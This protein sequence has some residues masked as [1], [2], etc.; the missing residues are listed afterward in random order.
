MK[1]IIILTIIATL[2]G[3][4]FDHVQAQNVSSPMDIRFTRQA[5]HRLVFDEKNSIPLSMMKPGKIVN[6]SVEYPLIKVSGGKTSYRVDKGLL[7]ASA[8]KPSESA[9][10][11]G[12]FNPFATYDIS[13]AD[14]EENS[15]EAGVEF[16]TP[17]N[18]N[19][20]M[21]LAGFKGDKCKTIRWQ[22]IVKGR[23]KEE[24]IVNLKKP[25]RGA[26]I[27]RVQVLGT[28]LNVYVV[29][30]GVNRVV[31]TRD[32]SKL[33]DLRRKE[34]IQSFEFRLLTILDKDESVVIKEAGSALTTGAG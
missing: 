9:L 5:V 13:F 34:H 3:F 19:R 15:G 27:L 16:A 29:Q 25:V 30:N 12:G 11:V 1:R 22:V 31:D 21:V 6:I 33:I 20:L 24:K 17:D 2:S 14:S 4:C 18:K 26:F 10:W 7:T 23:K 32:F 8:E 28:G